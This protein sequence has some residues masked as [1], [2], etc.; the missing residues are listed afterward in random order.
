MRQLKRNG[1]IT[2]A[3][4][5]K[6]CCGF[7]CTDKYWDHPRRCGENLIYKNSVRAR[8]GSPPQVRGKL[9]STAYLPCTK[10]ITP[11]GAGKTHFITIY[12]NAT[13]DHPRRCGENVSASFETAVEMG[14]PPQVRGKLSHNNIQSED[15]GI[16]PAGAGKTVLALVDITSLQDHPRRCGENLLYFFGFLDALGSPPQVRGKHDDF[17]QIYDRLRITPAGAGKTR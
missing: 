9:D 4:A 8:K 13:K 10:G 1:R 6:T 5:G 15:S 12:S 7:V 2:P 17:L 16:T 3:G 14:S 11:A